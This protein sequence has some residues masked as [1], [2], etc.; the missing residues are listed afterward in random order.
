MNGSIIF[1]GQCGSTAQYADWIG[2]ATGLPV[3]DVDDADADPSNYDFLVLGSSVIIYKLTIR[4]W[5]LRNLS[6]LQ[7]K[8]IILFTVS[9]APSGPKLD[10]WVADSLP[11]ETTMQ[12][13]HFALRGRMDPKKLGWWTSLILKIGAWKNDDPEAKRQ[14]LEGFDFMD[15]SSINP[16]LK[17]VHN[18]IGV[19]GIASA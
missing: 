13:A 15:K 1:S 16:I 10:G 17:R 14:E 8:P 5:V 6:S 9:G 12:M 18:F 2:E 7:N 3:F 11:K 4:K 19:N